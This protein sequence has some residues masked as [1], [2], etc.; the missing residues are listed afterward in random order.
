MASQKKQIRN[1]PRKFDFDN[2][3]FFY[4]KNNFE[5]LYKFV[6]IVLSILVLVGSEIRIGYLIFAPN[7]GTTN[8][9]YPYFL[10][11]TLVLDL[12]VI[13]ML[14]IALFSR[15]KHLDNGDGIKYLL[16]E[17]KSYRVVENF[18]SS[19]SV[20][21][22]TNQV[23]TVIEEVD[24]Y[25]NPI[26]YAEELFDDEEDIFVSDALSTAIVKEKEKTYS[27]LVED[28][29][30][31]F[32]DYGLN[33]N[34]AEALLSSMVF[35]P[36][37][38]A[39]D[40]A[41]YIKTIFRALSNPNYFIH[42]SENNTI[43]SEKTLYS[44]FEYAKS[45]PDS[46]IFIYIDEIPSKEFL[47]YMRPLYAYIDNTSDDYYISSQGL[48]FFIPHNVY[49]LVNIKK[50]DI[51]YEISRR[52]L[53]YIPI[54]RCDIKEVDASNE[55]KPFILSNNDIKNARRNAHD[56]FALSESTYKK[57]DNLFALTNE[58]NGYVLQN[59]IQRKIE[60]YTSLLLSINMSEDDVI[61]NVLS[62][63]IIRAAIISAEPQKL[64][65]EYNIVRLI[66]N[67]F[68]SDKLKETKAVVK[69]YISLFDKNGG[70]N[71]A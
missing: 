32:L 7:G 51:I 45:N 36:M 22:Q 46:P 9:S 17:E 11:V 71:N 68:G 4:Q 14:G 13:V 3:G 64:K 50:D 57:M 29:N 70:R 20:A 30:K 37:I 61:D 23:R 55:A 48:T 8:P 31:T 5:G 34:L 41:P 49:F 21:V 44:A 42:Y 18:S 43:A 66:E 6:L 53:R 40:I 25:G 65:T 35:S 59:K 33:G 54:L 12:L 1:Q 19:G 56:S 60:D 27:E 47:N 38:F 16:E 10:I 67:E 63:A 39:R 58:A 24:D 15:R 28:L 52:Y 62:N 26:I 2:Y 69:E